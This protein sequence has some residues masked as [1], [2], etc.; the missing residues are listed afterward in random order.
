MCVLQTMV[1]RSFYNYNVLFM[2]KIN[3]LYLVFIFS[4][5]LSGCSINNRKI[6]NN[7]NN[8]TN[9][10]NKI[11][12]NENENNISVVD[13]FNLMI[14][15]FK[16]CS[17]SQFFED[18]NPELKTVVIFGIN[19][20]KC[21]VM[22]NKD[23]FKD[24]IK[25]YFPKD[26]WIN[27][28]VIKQLYDNKDYGVKNLIDENC[29]KIDLTIDGLDEKNENVSEGVILDSEKINSMPI[30]NISDEDVIKNLPYVVNSQE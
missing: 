12:V 8:I 27:E 6:N 17:V 13:D 30:D 10:I 28:D 4:I 22:V 7:T 21:V 16:N 20:D 19:D 14:D 29:K 1:L 2:K 5:F 3:F 15:A 18:K 25:C 26:L 23:N 11:I 24:N 9:N